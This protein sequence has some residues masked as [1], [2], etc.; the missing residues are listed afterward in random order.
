MNEKANSLGLKNT[1]FVNCTGLP[2]PMQYSSAK[3]IT[4]IFADLITHKTYFDYSK[5]WMDKIEHSKNHTE[6]SNTNKLVRFYDGCDGGKTGFTNEAGF[7]LTATAK[8]GNMRLISAVIGAPDSKTRFNEV[9]TL[10]NKGFNLYENK[11]VLDKNLPLDAKIGV[12]GGKIKQVEVVP[13]NDFFVFTSKNSNDNIEI[14]YNYY[15][16]KAPVK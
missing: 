9:S 4:L 7:C 5:I 1:Q 13:E 2:K 12:L 16:V 14:D 3:D 6:I 8:R 11:A 15:S 10:L